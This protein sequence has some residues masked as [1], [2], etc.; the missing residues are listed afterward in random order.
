MS[1]PKAIRLFLDVDGV[2]LGQSE[3]RTIL[4]PH[5]GEFIDFILAHFECF[6]L[7]THCN[8]N[9]QTVLDYLRPFAPA[10]L[11]AK[12]KAIRPTSF[13]VLKT[14]P[15]AGNFFWIEDQPLAAELADLRRRGLGDRW[16]EVNTRQRS[17]D[18]LHAIRELTWVLKQRW[19]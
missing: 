10:D 13:R 18:L 11:L 15:L 2:L 3:G 16:I 6:W 19:H 1:M 14:E 12:M 8:G 17:D 4:A 9:V 5:A 7:T